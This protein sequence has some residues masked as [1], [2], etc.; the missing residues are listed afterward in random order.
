MKRTTRTLVAAAVCAATCSIAAAG[1]ARPGHLQAIRVQPDKA[2]D[3]TSLSSIVRSVTAGLDDD[4]AKAIAIYNFML[5]AYYHHAYPNEPG[6]I[7][8]LKGL[9]TYGW[10]LCGGEHTVLGALF[11][12]AGWNWRYVGWSNPG[13]T[14]IEVEYGGNWHYLDAFLKFYTWREDPALPNGRTI[15]SQADIKANP[16]L[17]T[18][19]LVLDPARQVYYHAGNRFEVI[20]G[21][22]NTQAP[23]FLVCGDAPAGVLSGVR[24]HRHAG[25]GISWG[26][27]HFDSPG[28]STDVD[29]APGCSLTL[30]WQ[31]IPGA[32]WW[33]GTQRRDTPP[34]HTCKDKDT[35]NCP[36]CGPI[37]EPYL[38]HNPARTFASGRL[39]F[40]PDLAAGDAFMAGLAGAENVRLAG[41]KLVPAEAGKPASITVRLQSP[42]VMSR[43]AGSAEGADKAELSTDDG[44]TFAPI[45]LDDFSDAVGGR[46]DV[47]VRLTFSAAL[48][49]PRLEAIVQANRGTLPYLSPG[50]NVVRVEAADPQA[51]GGN[52][53]VVTYVYHCGSRNRSPE[54]LAESG[55]ELARAHGA[56]WD[57][58]PTFVRK[59]FKAGDL[60]ATFTVDIP[61]PE[62]RYPVYPRMVFMRREIVAAGSRPLPLPEGAIEPRTA[63]ADELVAVPNPFHAGTQR[64]PAPKPV[65]IAETRRI[66]LAF[67]HVVTKSGQT[68]SPK[69][70]VKT[71]KDDSEAWVLL[72]A[73]T[74]GELPAAEQIAAARLVVPFA[75]GHAEARTKLGVTLLTAP[76]AKDQ[77]YAFDALGSVAGTAVLDRQ[78]GGGTWQP[79]RMV[80][81]N[82]TDAVRRIAREPAS[83]HGFGLRTLVDRSIDDGWTVRATVAADVPPVLEIDIAAPDN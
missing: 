34:H 38:A 46:Y 16:A 56:S 65:R 44:R 55:A 39:L 62:G 21:R 70:F 49:N 26:G 63:P 80:A 78:Q 4:D 54:R 76:V 75:E 5:A 29:L 35:R 12:E 43:A 27:H 2:P 1:E 57:E 47:Q 41:G 68:L 23:A 22:A 13:H 36:A 17:V 20:D 69:H 3:C 52:T 51:L 53:L 60:P 71:L 33:G 25:S 37:H 24:S 61:T 28:Y 31:G 10:A 58:A 64:P 83:F 82:V 40:Q 67:S 45:A 8:A 74:L 48:A 9:T 79:P 30:L 66:P 6:G 50:R 77:P 72:L 73:G 11:R 59:S 14:T 15:A 7:G 32:H 42:Y 81:F 18:E 19:N